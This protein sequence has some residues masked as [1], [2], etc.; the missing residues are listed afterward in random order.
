MIKLKSL[1]LSKL[2]REV[3]KK[4]G[5]STAVHDLATVATRWTAD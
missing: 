3:K 1:I 5:R 2:E 4:N